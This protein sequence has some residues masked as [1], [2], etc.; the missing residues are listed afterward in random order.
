MITLR[1]FR[2]DDVDALQSL[3]Y[4]T[5][6][7]DELRSLV[8]TW[9]HCDRTFE[10]L[11]ITHDDVPIGS[12][13]LYRLADKTV[14]IGPDVFLRYRRKG[15]AT[16]AMRLAMEL[17]KERGFLIA[18]GQVRIDNAA[19]IALHRKLGFETDEKVY[20]N[21]KGNEVFIFIKALFP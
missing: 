9:A 1:P 15:Y 12:V 6:S 18:F 14:S 3:C 16:E 7:K 8:E 2:T 13:S 10:M 5:A 19:S 21:G 11:A 4:P 20:R 17:A